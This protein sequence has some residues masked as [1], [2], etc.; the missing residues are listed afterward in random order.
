VTTQWT[1][2]RFAAGLMLAWASACGGDDD[3]DRDAAP[4]FDGSPAGDA[5]AHDAAVVD[6]SGDHRES[7]DSTNNPFSSDSG[8]AERTDLSLAAGSSRF[9]VC[10]QLDPA[11]ATSQV[12]DYDAFEFDVVGDQPVD[13]RIELLASDAGESSVGLD[14]YRVDDGP[15]EQI[16]SVPFRNGFALIA[17]IVAPPGRYWVSAAA[18]PPEPPSPVGYAILVSENQLSCP[19]AEGMP[20][21]E[22]GDA[23]E[24]RGNDMV[25]ILLGDP[26]A[27]TEAPDVPEATGLTLEPDAVALLRGTSAPIP[28]ADSYLDR[29]TYEIATGPMTDELELRLTWPDDDATD[30]DLYLFEATDPGNDY[31]VGLGNLPGKQRDVVM[32]LNVDPG[33]SYWLWVGALPPG[34]RAA[35]NP[36]AVPYDVT[37]CPRAHVAPTP[38]R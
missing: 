35:A 17:G 1:L 21:L 37:L 2:A 7:A 13:L 20:Y 38:P 26:P 3:G 15:P 22:A 6:C 12:A 27:P 18:W 4:V 8:S 19:A 34:D 31:S 10:G 29:D 9:W 5:S 24:D 32:T 23:P 11:Q 28:P 16:A 36:V 14:L 30:L 33:R 25:Q